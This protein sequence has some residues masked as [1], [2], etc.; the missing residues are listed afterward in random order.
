ME[1]FLGCVC[2]LT[3]ALAPWP[4]SSDEESWKLARLGKQAYEAFSCSTLAAEAG[5]DEVEVA[6]NVGLDSAR[7]FVEAL[8]AGKIEQAD[9]TSEVPMLV[10]WSLE[11]PTTDFIVGRIF[12][13]VSGY[14]SDAVSDEAS[15]FSE[16][17]N[18]DALKAERQRVAS[19]K[20]RENDCRRF[21]HK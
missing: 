6:F 17:G 19:L 18:Y 10:G 14:T 20:H 16:P 13:A 5:N 15:K 21:D 8:Q 11:G 9:F 7:R 1:R 4:A 3:I 2:I 12:Q